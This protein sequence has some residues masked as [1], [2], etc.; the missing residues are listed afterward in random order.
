MQTVLLI[1]DEVASL[2]AVARIL[3]HDGFNVVSTTT[4]DEVLSY[5]QSHKVDLLVADIILA[6]STSGIEVALLSRRHCPDVPVLLISGTSVGGWSEN[7]FGN[8]EKLLPSRIDFLAKPFTARVLLNMVSLLMSDTYSGSNIPSL[9]AGMAN[10]R[11]RMAKERLQPPSR[12]GQ[13]D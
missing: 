5:C 4:P 11:E 9:V 7:D 3:E 12:T 1:D 10:L 13:P 6:S 2:T 8:I